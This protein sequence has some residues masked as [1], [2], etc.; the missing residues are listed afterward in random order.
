MAKLIDTREFRDR[1][2][3]WFAA[4]SGDCNPMHMDAVAARRTIAHFPVV[5]GIHAVIW[6]LDAL[7]QIY[8]REVGQAQVQVKVR[9]VAPILVGDEVRA[10]LIQKSEQALRL[11]VMVEETTA[12]QVSITRGGQRPVTE[13]TIESG[14]T[15]M[16]TAPLALPFCQMISAGGAIPFATDPDEIAKRFPAAARVLD[17][18]RLVALACSSFL[19]GMICPGLHSIYRGLELVTTGLNGNAKDKLRF[20]V[21]D[22][23]ER[24]RLVRLAVSGG[25][26]AGLIEAHA[27]PEPV[28]QAGL[29]SLATKVTPGEFSDVSALIVGGSRGLGEVAAKILAA[30][31]AHTTVSYSVGEADARRVQGEITAFGSRCDVLHYDVRSSAPPQLNRLATDPSQVY[32]MATPAISRHRQMGFMESLLREF[33]AFYVVGFYDLCK[34]LTQRY[35][36]DL[37]IFYPSSVFV[38][39]R[40]QN[41]MEY[42]MAKACGEVLCADMQRVEK[43]GRILVRRLPRLL[44]DQTAA[45]IGPPST[46]PVDVMLPIV[47]E[48]HAD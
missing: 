17:A 15:V 41:M 24:F 35:G 44:T 20:G 31:G 36:R 37:S 16:P 25:G 46:D 1:D 22:S 4:V 39:N 14:L 23:D 26:W 28:T 38:H 12:I 40:P 18:R 7:F 9:F 27:R 5:H 10:I 45:I 8:L 43:L 3:E 42:A 32:F 47:R 29:G 21:V 2:Q 30:G 34:E 19:V 6:A 48:L 13:D 33:L 11:N